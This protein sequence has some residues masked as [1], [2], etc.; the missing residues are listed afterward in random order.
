MH[1]HHNQNN[2]YMYHSTKASS[3]PFVFPTSFPSCPSQPL[4]PQATTSH[5]RLDCIFKIPYKRNHTKCNLLVWFVS[6]RIS[7]LKGVNSLF[8]LLLNSI[9][10]DGYTPDC[11][12]ILLL[13]DIWF[14]SSFWL[15]R[16]KLL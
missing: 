3:C 8:I 12:Y 5:Y 15:S 11:L 6:L 2:E 14:I 9:T 4:P 13:M 16:I 1:H 10:L 7:I